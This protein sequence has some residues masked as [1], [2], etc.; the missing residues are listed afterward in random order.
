MCPHDDEVDCLFLGV[1]DDVL[2]CGTLPQDRGDMETGLLEL[3]REPFQIVLASCR[4]EFYQLTR[5]GR[6]QLHEETS[7]W[8]RRAGAIARIL[9]AKG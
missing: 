7:E 9:D 4:P 2:G 6:K 8:A 1:L 3:H 5:A